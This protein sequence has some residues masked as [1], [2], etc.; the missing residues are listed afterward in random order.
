M[1]VDWVLD[2][3]AALYHLGG[4]LAAPLPAGR[5]AVSVISELEMLSFA[6]LSPEEE[7]VT[8]AFLAGVAIQDLTLDIRNR[9]VRLRREYRL[10]L[11]DAII[12]ATAMS[13]ECT[14]LSNDRRLA[15]LPSL[16]CRVMPLRP[17]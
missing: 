7:R 3:N 8:R 9:T 14:L 17:S 13:L 12:A 4:R 10:K 16:S 6:G 15:A 5:Y 1:A 11:P 2:T